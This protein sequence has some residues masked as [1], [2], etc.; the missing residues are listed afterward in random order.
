MRKRAA[1]ELIQRAMHRSSL[2][3]RRLAVRTGISEGRISDYL[4]G[5]YSPGSEQLVRIVEATGH[6]LA[7][8]PDFDANG[9]TLPELLGLA[10]ALSVDPERPA[11]TEHLPRFRDLITARG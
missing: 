8:Q 10:E 4:S 7:L 1:A 11:R 6:Q 9:L 2:S 3:A 5:R